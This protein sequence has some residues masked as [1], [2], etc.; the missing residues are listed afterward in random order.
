VRV[1]T[2]QCSVAYEQR[3]DLADQFVP[4]RDIVAE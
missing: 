3:A 2:A 1:I 4:S